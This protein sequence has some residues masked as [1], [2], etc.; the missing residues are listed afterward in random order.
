MEAVREGIEAEGWQLSGLQKTTSHHFEGRWSG[1]STRSAYL[2]FHHPEVPGDVSIDVFLDET[3]RG[4]EG[5]LALVVDGPSLAELGSV[6]RAFGDLAAAAAGSLPGGYRTPITLRFRLGGWDTVAGEARSEC[7]FKLHIPRGA[8][9]AGRSAVAALCSST[10]R[11]FRG[12]LEHPLVRD[13]QTD[14]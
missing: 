8:V 4:L 3:S 2:F 9:D 1:D 10:T 7:R 14:A 5:N 12:L 13:F 11:A 6:E